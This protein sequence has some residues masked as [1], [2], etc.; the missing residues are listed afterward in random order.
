MSAAARLRAFAG[1]LLVRLL[2][3]AA[4]VL[5]AFVLR[6]WIAAALAD[7]A[8]LV[9]VLAVVLGG[10]SVLVGLLLDGWRWWES[11]Q[12]AR[13]KHRRRTV[14]SFGSRDWRD[15]WDKPAA[16][17]RVES[18]RHDAPAEI[19]RGHLNVMPGLEPPNGTTCGCNPGGECLAFTIADDA[20]AQGVPPAADFG[21]SCKL[22]GCGL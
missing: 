8:R 10:G 1:G 16:S 17:A 9:L 3:V 12:A 5:L 11:R 7:L 22:P 14:V 21:R 13:R 19:P 4:A 2:V 18:Y 6:S 15:I 20:P